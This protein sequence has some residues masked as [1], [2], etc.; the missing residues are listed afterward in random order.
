MPAPG[1]LEV[2]V[3]GVSI[4]HWSTEGT[5]CTV[6]LFDQGT[7]AS[8]EVRGGAPASRELEVLGPLMT[9]QQVDAALLTGGSA[10]GLASADGVMRFLQEQGRGDRQHLLLVI[11]RD[12][13]P[14]NCLQF[15]RLLFAIS[16]IPC[17]VL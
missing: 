5:G 17:P 8:V 2:T 11:A 13:D 6:V 10:F 4:G 7:V 3:P 15:H 14:Q 9:V 1:D 12:Y 16:A